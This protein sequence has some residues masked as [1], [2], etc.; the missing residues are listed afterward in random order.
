MSS[1]DQQNQ[2]EGNKEADR[3]YR[4]RTERFVNSEQGKAKIREAGNVSKDEEQDIE[5]AEAEGRSHAKERD[6]QETFDPK[7]RA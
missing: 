3:N 7:R 2:G 5:R 1:S 6:P 4:E